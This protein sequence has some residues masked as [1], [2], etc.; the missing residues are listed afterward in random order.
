MRK[1]GS[2]WAAVLYFGIDKSGK[3]KYK[4]FSG[5][6]T[7]KEAEKAR[8]RS[9]KKSTPESILKQQRF[10]GRL[11]EEMARGQEIPS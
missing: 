1:R 3:R 8:P 4:W 5:F 2:K 9:S 7:K 11:Y 6:S 10:Y